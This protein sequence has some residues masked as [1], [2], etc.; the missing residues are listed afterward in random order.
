MKRSFT[1]VIKAANATADTR[2]AKI[3]LSRFK[4]MKKKATMTTLSGQPD[5]ENGVEGQPVKPTT[6]EM[7]VGKSMSVDLPP[8]SFTMLT[9]KL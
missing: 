3:D 4:S 7:T 9:V 5:D 1:F 6:K 2:T 8:Y